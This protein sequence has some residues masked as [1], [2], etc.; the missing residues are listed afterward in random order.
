MRNYQVIKVPHEFLSYL[1]D[2]KYYI[3]YDTF[4]VK[5]IYEK[6]GMILLTS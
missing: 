3:Y 5:V 1:I 2:L 6:P 4:Y